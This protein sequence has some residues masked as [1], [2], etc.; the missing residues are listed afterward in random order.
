MKGR[1]YCFYTPAQ[2]SDYVDVDPQVTFTNGT[3]NND[4]ECIYI[5]I[6]DDIDFEDEHDFHVNISMITPPIASGIG[7][8]ISVTIQDNSGNLCS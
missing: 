3:A 4:S 7:D 2:G 6:I 8:V 1:F 5:E